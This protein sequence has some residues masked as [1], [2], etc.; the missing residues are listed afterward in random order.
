[1]KCMLVLAALFTTL[2][3]AQ[4]DPEGWYGDSLGYP[5]GDHA[6]GLDDGVQ[7]LHDSPYG[8]Y[9][10][11]YPQGVDDAE[12]YD[13][14]DG[15]L[16]D[17]GDEGTLA[18]RWV[19]PVDYPMSLVRREVLEPRGVSPTIFANAAKLKKNKFKKQKFN[20]ANKKFKKFNR[21]QKTVFI[22]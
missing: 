16:D 2:V 6:D 1:M 21:K 10:A 3:T 9:G 14:A 12:D 22:G 5:D 13:G 19:V 17:D 4:M 7:E 8:A 20:F 11:G 18:R 15:Y